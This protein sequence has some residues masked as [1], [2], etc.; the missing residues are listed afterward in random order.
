MMFFTSKSTSAPTPK[1]KYVTIY[2]SGFNG[3]HQT[4]PPSLYY[5]VDYL[6]ATCWP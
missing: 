5:I 2:M 6:K 4:K 3:W 1:P